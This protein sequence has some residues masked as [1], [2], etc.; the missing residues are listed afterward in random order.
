MHKAV[1]NDAHDHAKQQEGKRI[2]QMIA[3]L[4][5]ELQHNRQLKYALYVLYLTCTRSCF[6]NTDHDFESRPLLNDGE[7]DI[8]A[9][10]KE[11]EQRGNPTWFDVAWLYAECYLYR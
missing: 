2:M 1:G 8:A 6:V 11:L 7:P 10:N 9:Y 5:Y 3:E 4:K